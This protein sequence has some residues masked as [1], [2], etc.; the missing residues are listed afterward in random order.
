M[1]RIIFITHYEQCANIDGNITQHMLEHLILVFQQLGRQP[2]LAGR[3]LVKKSAF[4][5]DSLRE[6]TLQATSFKLQVSGLK[7][8]Q[9]SSFKLQATGYRLQASALIYYIH[10]V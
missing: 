1:Q 10:N 5:R 9:A 8:Q 6:M 2:Q 3:A 4:A 7:L